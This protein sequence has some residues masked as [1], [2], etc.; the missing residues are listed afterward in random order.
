MLQLA[1]TKCRQ[2]MAATTQDIAYA[3]NRVDH[4][5]ALFTFKAENNSQMIV[6]LMRTWDDELILVHHYDIVTARPGIVEEGWYVRD[7]DIANAKAIEL[8]PCK[9]WFTDDEFVAIKIQPTERGFS[10]KK[11]V[12]KMESSCAAEAKEMNWT[13]SHIN[14]LTCVRWHMNHNFIVKKDTTDD[15]IRLLGEIFFT[16]PESTLPVVRIDE[17]DC[18]PKM[19]ARNRRIWTDCPVNSDR[20]KGIPYAA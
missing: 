17:D 19:Y 18:V 4:S 8:Y 15:Q 11:N 20:K 9:W 14:A 16:N 6:Q 7:L 10:L 1:T 13:A 12:L 3:F 2:N 5:E